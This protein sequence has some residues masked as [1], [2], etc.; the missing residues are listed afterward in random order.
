MFSGRAFKPRIEN[1]HRAGEWKRVPGFLQWERGR[2]CFLSLQNSKHVCRGRVRACHYDPWG[3][4]GMGTKVSD[5]ACLPM[6]D[7]GHE[8]QHRIGWPRFEA[9]YKFAG[10]DI[11]TRYWL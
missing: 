10:R 11:V 3:D 1:S 9:R 2:P 7:G 4:K 6:C 8:E 5:N